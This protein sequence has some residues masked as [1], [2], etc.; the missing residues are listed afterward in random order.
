M[1]SLCAIYKMSRSALSAYKDTTRS[2]L[3][4]DKAG[5]ASFINDFK[6]NQSYELID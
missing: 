2:V 6:S 4:A 3:D 5:T 1:L